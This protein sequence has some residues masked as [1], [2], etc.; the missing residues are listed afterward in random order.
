[1][2]TIILVLSSM[3]SI[4]SNIGNAQ[5]KSIPSTGNDLRIKKLVRD[6]IGKTITL[7]FRSQEHATGTLI[8]ADGFEFVVETDGI[9][10]NYKTQTIRS[11]TMEAGIGE[12]ILV[13]VSACFA[14]GLG[15]GAAA[16]SVTGISS[17]AVGGVGLIFGFLGGWLGYES[18]FQDVEIDLP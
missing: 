8:S 17:G 9:Q 18:F 14:A 13:V 15:A 16:L 12:G 4:N 10:E 2:M 3:V 5:E 11:F 7:N 1:M 6:V